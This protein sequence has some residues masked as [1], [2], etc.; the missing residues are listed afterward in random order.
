MIHFNCP[1]RN[2]LLKFL[3][4]FVFSIDG[5]CSSPRLLI[6]LGPK[7]NFLAKDLQRKVDAH[8]VKGTID[9]IKTRIKYLDKTNSLH[10]MIVD[11]KTEDLAFFASQIGYVSLH[12]DEKFKK[13]LRLVKSTIASIPTTDADL[14]RLDPTDAGLFY[15]LMM[16]VDRIFKEHNLA[17][18]AACGTLLGVVRHQG[19]IP[20]DDDLD[21]AIFAKD[22][23][24]LKE[25][26]EAFS[27]AGL[28]MCYHSKYEFYKIYFKNGRTIAQENGDIY[29]WTYPF[30]DVFPLIEDKGKYTYTGRIWQETCPNDYFFSK[31]VHFPLPE[32]PFGPL[33][34]PVPHLRTDYLTRLYGEDWNDVAYLEYSHRLEQTLTKIKVDLVDRSPPAYI[35]P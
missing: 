9:E 22:V 34:I 27:E 26:K 18:W 35:L 25:L 20:W 23:P 12:L 19:M 5:F 6:T 28:E 30:L 1:V 32:L 11:D 29:P 10:V 31:D 24:L 4:F 15:D 16:K 17:Y 7:C 13:S 2:V 3:F 8:V 21:I 33:S 14:P